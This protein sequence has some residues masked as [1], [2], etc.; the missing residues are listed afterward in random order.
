MLFFGVIGTVSTLGT[1]SFVARGD[2][3]KFMWCCY[4]LPAFGTLGYAAV[5]FLKWAY[6]FESEVEALEV[7]EGDF[8][9]MD[10]NGDG[11]ISKYEFVTYI[12]QQYDMVKE[13]DLSIL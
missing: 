4:T 12:L 11:K 2:F 3:Q 7:D 9:K 6:E 10:E 1:G 5:N 8:T 13:H